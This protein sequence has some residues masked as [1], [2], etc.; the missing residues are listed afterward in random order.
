MNAALK[1]RLV[2]AVVL[3]A[4]AVIFLP[5]LLDGSGAREDIAREVQIPERPEVPAVDLEAT[6]EPVAPAEEP[7]A[8]APDLVA[9]APAE[10][11]EP[12]SEPDPEPDSAPAS[13]PEPDSEPAAD[14]SDGPSAWVVQTGS[15]SRR[16]NAEAQRDRLQE[17]GFDAFLNEAQRDDS[18]I[19]RVRVG[20]IGREDDAH[21]LRDQLERD[22]DLAGI[23]VSHP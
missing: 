6:P 4:L 22:E 12:A 2:G 23:V 9:D 8:E 5:M 19:W 14:A 7:V 21:E 17:A 1:Q 3:V 15:F 13:E 11:R 16:E 18:R 20:P 10:E